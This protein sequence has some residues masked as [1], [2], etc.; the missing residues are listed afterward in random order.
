MK[1]FIGSTR[2]DFHVL[3]KQFLVIKE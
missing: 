1:I 3:S 2:G